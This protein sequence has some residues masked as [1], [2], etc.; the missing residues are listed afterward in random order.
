MSHI[1]EGF[2]YIDPNG[3][4]VMNM[5]MLF[6]RL[7]YF[8][9]GC[10]LSSLPVSYDSDLF[11]ELEIIDTC[12]FSKFSYCCF[13]NCFSDFTTTFGEHEGTLFMTN[14]EKFCCSCPFSCT[15]TSCTWFEPK[16]RRD[17]S[18]YLSYRERDVVRILFHTGIV[19]NFFKN[20]RKKFA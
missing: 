5:G 19:G 1:D 15:D 2:F 3:G 12:F 17:I 11:P 8:E 13:F 16:E 10:F 18:F 7:F 9:K 6:S 14:T 4:F 20:R